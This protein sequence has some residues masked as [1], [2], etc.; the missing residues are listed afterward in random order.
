MKNILLVCT[1]NTCR[2][3]M[4]VY[5]FRNYFGDT[6]RDQ[7]YNFQ[8]AGITA[9]SGQ[10]MNEMADS[11]LA[12]RGISADGHKSTRL[13]SQQI[14]EADLI[15]TMTRRQ[16]RRISQNYP[17]AEDYVFTLGEFSG[18]DKEVPDPFGGSRE[19]YQKTL[20]ELE[21]MIV[22]ASER[23]PEFFAEVESRKIEGSGVMKVAIG[24]DHAGYSLKESIK[25]WLQDREYEVLDQGTDSTE[26]VDYPEYASRVARAVAKQEA[27]LGIL[28][29]GTGLGMSM[30]A[31][32][33]SGIR[34]ARCQ[35]TYSARMA[36]KHNN[37]NVL[38]LGERVIG[39]GLALS[40][41][42]AFLAAEFSGGR[43]ERRVNKI[44]KT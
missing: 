32:N 28:I 35:D 37:A 20:Q 6:D 26:S 18:V 4:A 19:L 33:V 29:C 16:A 12:D 44:E 2:S 39:E 43:H 11:V 9:V 17:C 21:K 41:V 31:N 40:V 34:A 27:E 1:G 23:L 8:S 3:P 15:L 22:R 5:L 7:L 24:S 30:A 14:E 36:R 10:N 25:E 13:S 42:E 38:T